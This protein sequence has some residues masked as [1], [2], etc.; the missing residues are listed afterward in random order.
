MILTRDILPYI[1]EHLPNLTSL[2]RICCVD[3]TCRS[4]L[5]EDS[6]SGRHWIRVSRKICG[7]EYW[8]SELNDHGRYAAM[9]HLCPWISMPVTFELNT[10][11]S[12]G[13][14]YASVDL[15]DMRIVDDEFPRIVLL[16]NIHENDHVKGGRRI[17]HRSAREEEDDDLIYPPDEKQFPEFKDQR[18][19]DILNHIKENNHFYRLTSRY[20]LGELTD[21]K[22]VHQ[23]LFAA[24]FSEGRA[25]R[26]AT[27]L[28]IDMKDWGHIVHELKL[29]DCSPRCVVFKPAAMWYA[30]GDGSVIYHGP[31]ESRNIL[32]LT[33]KGSGRITKAFFQIMDG[34]VTEAL[35]LIGTLDLMAIHIPK[36]KYTLFDIAADPYGANDFDAPLPPEAALLLEMEPR[37]ANSI[38]MI[39]SAV[40]KMDLGAIERADETRWISFK[41]VSDAKPSGAVIGDVL[42]LL[43]SKGIMVTHRY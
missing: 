42:K 38:W 30:T 6:S 4:Y 29:L 26:Y 18:E 1:C 43:D 16:A 36:T 23:N 20:G 34:N 7:V 24:I 9:L 33:P 27:V 8:D 21:V 28:F 11:N 17:I 39:R 37:F 22:I 13:N 15:L 31:N 32:N 25:W 35:N 5:I 19:I 3:S 14:L 10:L 2:G 41:D 12:Y 40:S